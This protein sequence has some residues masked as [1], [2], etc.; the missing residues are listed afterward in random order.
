MEALR[1]SSRGS[2]G[3]DLQNASLAIFLS[4]LLFL[5]FEKSFFLA[6]IKLNELCG[7]LVYPNIAFKKIVREHLCWKIVYESSVLA[8]P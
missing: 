2:R 1:L 8:G 7:D 3:F 4:F 5:F 6:I